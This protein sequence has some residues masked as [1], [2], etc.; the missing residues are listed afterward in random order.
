VSLGETIV[1]ISH[2]FVGL[3]KMILH[4]LLGNVKVRVSKILT[5]EKISISNGLQCSCQVQIDIPKE[6]TSR[7]IFMTILNLLK[8]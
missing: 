6:F 2:I 5:Y 3:Q 1:F 8:L 7:I 4:Q